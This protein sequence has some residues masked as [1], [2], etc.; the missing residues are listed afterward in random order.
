M[1]PW[2]TCLKRSLVFPILLF[3]SISLHWSLRS[4]LISLCYSLEFCIQMEGT[5][6]SLRAQTKPCMHQDPVERS[7]GPTR[8]WPRLSCV[9]PGV[10]SGGVGR[11]WP[12][13]GWR[14][15]SVAVHAWDLL[16]EVAIIFITSTIVWPQVNNREGTQLHLS[17]EIWIKDLLSMALPIRK[18]PSFPHSQ[19]LP[20][21]SI[22]KPLILIHQRAERMKTT[23]TEK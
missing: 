11:W 16:K 4:F 8:D 22:H 17:T 1:F 15:L 13:A 19:Y 9:C 10:S 18:R 6:K 12:A 3:S 14:V 5:N 7:S 2:V 21:G 20:S 23:I